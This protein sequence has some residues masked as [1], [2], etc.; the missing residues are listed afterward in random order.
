VLP[1]G[2]EDTLMT[3]SNQFCIKDLISAVHKMNDLFVD[4]TRLY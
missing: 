2:E 1:D 4:E 3:K